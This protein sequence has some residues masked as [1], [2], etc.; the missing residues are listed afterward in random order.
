M[1]QPG[2]K[3]YHT[4]IEINPSYFLQ[5]AHNHFFTLLNTINLKKISF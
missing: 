1:R 2:L 3:A 5:G 4:A